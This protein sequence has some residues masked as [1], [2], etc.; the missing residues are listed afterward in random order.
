M[1][2]EIFPPDRIGADILNEFI[3]ESLSAMKLPEDTAKLLAD[4]LIQ[5]DLWGHPSHGIMR[6]FWYAERIKSGAIQCLKEPEWVIDA[7]A[8]ATL[9]GMDGVG[10]SIAA[11][12]MQTA[13]QKAKIYGIAA[14]SVRNSG[15]F[16]TAMYFTK[17]AADA[18]CIG[19]LSSNA[20]PAM[21][22]WG[23]IETLVGNNPWSWAAPA[24]RYPCF[25]LD[26]ANTAVAR[27]KLYHAKKTGQ[28][29]PEG[30]AL[31]EHGNMTTDPVA[32]IAGQILPMAGHK[33][34]AISM[35]MDVLSG[36]LSAGQFGSSITGPYKKEGKSGAGHLIIVIDI[37][38]IRPIKEFCEDMESLITSLKASKLAPGSSEIYYPGEKE[39]KNHEIASDIGILISKSVQHELAY[40]AKLLGIKHPF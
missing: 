8:V 33:G 27:G 7:G 30:W 16:G 25:M 3:L 31:D 26:I 18:N 1:N 37:T 4:S 22:P 14:I 29:I 6:L 15:H 5:A 2:T 10:Q 13:I 20:S 28:A 36:V 34:Y 9:D 40:G 21:A 35:A 24:G 17:M 32:G 19:F 38:K 39:A 23:G 12:A 11:I